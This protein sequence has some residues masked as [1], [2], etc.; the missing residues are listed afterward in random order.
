MLNSGPEGTFPIANWEDGLIIG[1]KSRSA[2]GGR[3]PKEEICG[4]V[5]P[6][7]A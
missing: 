4:G 2:T 3:P 5:A 6:A 1:T 7:Q